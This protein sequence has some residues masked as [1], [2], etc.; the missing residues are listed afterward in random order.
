MPSIQYIE[1]NAALRDLCRQLAG[2]NFIAVDTEFIREKNYYPRL[3]LVQVQGRGQLACIDPLVISDF[4]P[5]LDLFRDESIIKVLHS[6]SQDMAVFLHAFGCIPKPVYDTQ[7]A[8]SL[9]GIGDQV[10]YAKLVQSVLGIQLDKSHTRTDWSRRPLDQA[11]INYAADDVRYLAELYPIQRDYLISEGR[12]DWLASDFEAVTEECRY[13]P[14]PETAWRRV[15]GFSG[16]QGVDLAILKYMAEYREQQAMKFDKP[17]QFILRDNQLIDLVKAKPQKMRDLERYRGYENV[18]RRH[19]QALLDCV[20]RGLAAPREEWPEI[21]KGKPLTANQ[22]V[23]ADVLMALLKQESRKSGVGISSMA[24]RKQV[25]CLV[26]GERDIPLLG[27]WR[28]ELAGKTLMDFLSGS[29][30]LSMSDQQLRL[31]AAP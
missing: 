25:E 24:S 2:A 1:S 29:L 26:R 17:R 12:L 16:M 13:L 3:C 6:V 5:L 23:V 20:A 9:T 10:S 28:Y 4:T 11:Q 7:I 14:D 22:Q 31:T 27:G 8:A 18:I 15:K 19:G 21:A 30:A